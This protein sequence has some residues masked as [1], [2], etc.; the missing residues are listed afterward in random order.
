MS[1]S[2]PLSITYNAVAKAMEKVNQDNYAGFYYLD[3][4]LIRF[5][6]RIAH[7][8]PTGYSGGESHLM[9]LDAEILDTDYQL[10]RKDSV[11]IAARTDSAMQNTTELAYLV[12]ALVGLATTGNVTKLLKRET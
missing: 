7:T 9:R 3:D 6:G 8:V 10:K 5:H 12:N 2:N 1:F 4:D 11:W